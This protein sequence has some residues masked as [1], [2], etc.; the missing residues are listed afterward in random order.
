MPAA[1]VSLLSFS[2]FLRSV[3]KLHSVGTS[4]MRNFDLY[5]S[6]RWSFIFSDTWLTQRRLWIVLELIPKLYASVFSD[7]SW[8][9]W[10]LRDTTQLWYSFHNIHSILVVAFSVLRVKALSGAFYL[11]V[12]QPCSAGNGHLPFGRMPILTRWSRTRTFQTVSA[13]LSKNSVLFFVHDLGSRDGNCIGPL[14][15]TVLFLST[16]NKYLFLFQHHLSPF[17]SWPLPLFQFSRVWRQSFVIEA[18]DPSFSWPSF[19]IADSL[20]SISSDEFPGRTIPIRFRVYQ[21][22]VSSICT[23]FPGYH[24]RESLTL[25]GDTRAGECNCLVTTGDVLSFALVTPDFFLIENKSLYP[26]R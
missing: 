5:F 22:H 9:L 26:E 24:L 6:K 10:V 8:W 19:S 25:C 1:G 7:T 16:G 4:R 12:L 2:L 14:A 11:V 23:D 17:D 21:T 20:A 18:S 15:N 3:L 13:R